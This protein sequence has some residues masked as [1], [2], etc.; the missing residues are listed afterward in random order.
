VIVLLQVLLTA[1]GPGFADEPVL[2]EWV[3]KVDPTAFPGNTILDGCEAKGGA[4]ATPV[5]NLEAC[6]GWSLFWHD[7][8]HTPTV[9]LQGERYC[10]AALGPFVYGSVDFLP[11]FRDE[12]G[13]TVYQAEAFREI[14]VTP[15]TGNPPVDPP[16]VITFR[17]ESALSSSDFDTDFD[18]GF[19]VL[20][21]V[22]LSDWYRLEGSYFGSYSWEDSASARFQDTDADDD[23]ATESVE[24][25]L[26]SPFSSFGDIQGRSGLSTLS[27]ADFDPIAGLDYNEFASINFSSRLDNAELNLRRRLRTIADRHVAAEVSGML[28]LRYVQVREDFGYLTQATAGDVGTQNTVDVQT[29]NDLFGVQIGGLSQFLVHHRAWIDFEIKGAI[30]FNQANSAVAASF[31]DVDPD[32]QVTTPASGAFSSERDR[33]SFLGELSLQLNYQFAPAWTVRA[34][35]NAL[36]LTGVALATENFSSDVD[37]LINGPG[38]VDHD[39]RVVYHGPNISIVWAR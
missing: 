33:T 35:Y 13:S 11:L 20:I 32:A 8:C 23:P 34:G 31:Y 39:G 15:P 6:S 21:G 16:D 28:G 38:T 22:A 29:D 19:R 24:G 5:P 26:L 25:N 7:P 37:T 17:R 12:S 2:E 1:G 30:L 27:Q 10:H 3:T 9:C 36:W 4:C 18:T 14:E